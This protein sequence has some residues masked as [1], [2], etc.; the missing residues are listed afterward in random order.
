MS[1]KLDKYDNLVISFE[2][3]RELLGFSAPAKLLFD[4]NH[5]ESKIQ[6]L[7]DSSYLD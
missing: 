2:K 5:H 3:D 7:V 4:K 1:L 6:V